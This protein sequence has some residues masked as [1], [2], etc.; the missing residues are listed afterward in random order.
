MSK[1]HAIKAEATDEVFQEQC[2]LLERAAP[3]RAQLHLNFRDILHA[4][5]HICYE[6]NK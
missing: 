6:K 3:V 1:S 4:Q 5:G 2:F